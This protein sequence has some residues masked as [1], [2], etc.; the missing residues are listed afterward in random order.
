MI[1]GTCSMRT[2]A[3]LPPPRRTSHVPAQSSVMICPDPILISTRRDDEACEGIFWVYWEWAM[4]MVGRSLLD[5]R[6]ERIRSM[7]MPSAFTSSPISHL[8]RSPSSQSLTSPDIAPVFGL[9]PHHG[10]GSLMLTGNLRAFRVSGCLSNLGRLAVSPDNPTSLKS[11]PCG[12][13]MARV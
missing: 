11:I 2:G 5:D 4:G 3:T 9:V 13:E 10:E 6:I 8:D 12:G 1:R 7:D